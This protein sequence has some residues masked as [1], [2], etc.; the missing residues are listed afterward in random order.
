MCV[1]A[2]STSIKI[3]GLIILM[4]DLIRLNFLIHQKGR[5]LEGSVLEDGWE[6]G[7]V[8]LIAR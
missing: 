3:G 5:L 2:L 1:T 4:G 7:G 6:V 8:G